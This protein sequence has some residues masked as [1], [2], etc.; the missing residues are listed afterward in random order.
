MITH[1]A[2]EVLT[3][4]LS[5]LVRQYGL[6]TNRRGSSGD[7]ALVSRIDALMTAVR[8]LQSLIEQRR[9]ERASPLDGREW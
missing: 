2:V 4:R 3:G 8:G 1:D 7:K 6:D 9:E 5:D